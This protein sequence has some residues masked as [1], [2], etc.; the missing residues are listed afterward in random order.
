[1]ASA[2]VPLK[3][4]DA[5]LSMAP[6]ALRTESHLCLTAAGLRGRDESVHQTTQGPQASTL[7]LR[8]KKVPTNSFTRKALSV[9]EWM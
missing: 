3:A 1:M 6:E 5:P 2:T 4:T 7:L 9:V 8:V